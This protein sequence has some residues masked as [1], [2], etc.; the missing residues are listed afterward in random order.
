M[1]ALPFLAVQHFF[2]ETPLWSGLEPHC[3][4]WPRIF[5]SGMA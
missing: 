1:A 3:L 5:L 4:E 2:L